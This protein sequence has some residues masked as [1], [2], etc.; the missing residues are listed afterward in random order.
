MI[1]EIFLMELYSM[2]TKFESIFF[3]HVNEKFNL[4]FLNF[5]RSSF[6]SKIGNIIYWS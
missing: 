4:L 1:E 2:Y 3:K 5:P 6:S